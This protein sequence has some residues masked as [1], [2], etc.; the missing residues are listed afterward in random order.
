MTFT[1]HADVCIPAAPQL[2]GADLARVTSI[3]ALR[4]CLLRLAHERLPTARSSVQADAVLD[5]DSRC[6]LYALAAAL[7]LCPDDVRLTLDV[8]N[9]PPFLKPTGYHDANEAPLT[10]HDLVTRQRSCGTC[11]MAFLAPQ[12][13]VFIRYQNLVGQ[14][15]MGHD[16]SSHRWQGERVI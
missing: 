14:L 15:V 4:R 10:A 12:K 3:T 16:P 9:L 2:T 1:P 11:G 5:A 6:I 7:L 13:T 8:S